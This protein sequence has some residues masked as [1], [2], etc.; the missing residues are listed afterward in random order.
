MGN[1]DVSPNITLGT[2]RNTPNPK[3]GL[4][5][6]VKTFLVLSKYYAIPHQ[7]WAKVRVALDF[8]V[9]FQVNY[10]NS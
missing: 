9:L 10:P 7:F 2:R 5:N 4:T 8:G 3:W 6:G 1:K